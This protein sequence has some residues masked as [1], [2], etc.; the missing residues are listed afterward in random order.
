MTLR[1]MIKINRKKNR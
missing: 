1:N